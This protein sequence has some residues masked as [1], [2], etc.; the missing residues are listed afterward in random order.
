MEGPLTLLSAPAGFGKT[1]L[2]TSWLA[3]SG[4]PAAWFSVEPE[5]NDP[6]RFFTYLLAA[7]QRLDRHL[8]SSLLPLLQS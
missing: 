6:V 4:T 1:T 3:Q 8:G 5:D 2:L 7:L